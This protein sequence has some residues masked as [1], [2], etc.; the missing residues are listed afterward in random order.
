M[1]VS[2]ILIKNGEVIDPA[3]GARSRMDVAISGDRIV[4]MAPALGVGQAK[5]TYDASGKL[6]V[7]GLIDLHTHLGFEVHR[8]V[9]AAVDV[10]PQAGVTAAVDMGSVGAFTFPWYRQR[11]L[12]TCPVR[13]FSFINISSIG[14]IAIHQPYYVNYYADGV[15]LDREDT[16]RTID[17][18]RD[19]VLGIKVFGTAT[20]AG[21]WVLPALR[22]AREVADLTHVPIA[23]HVSKEPPPLDEILALLRQGDMITH[24]YTPLEQGILDADGKVRAVVRE[25]RERGVLFDLGHGS[26]SFTFE[27]AR[28]AMEQ[29]FLPDTIS[30]DVYYS[31]VDGPVKDLPT[32]MGK[33]LALGLPIEEVLS[34]V[35]TAPAKAMGRPDLG[36]LREGG[37]ADLAVLSLQEGRFGYIDSRKQVVEGPWKIECELTVCRGQLIYRKEHAH[38]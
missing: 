10:C 20:M 36:A 13:L 4:S 25:A 5:Q 18:N 21:E 16:A 37:P 15:Y 2:D 30:T 29:G 24:S 3:S 8:K 28:K 23:V 17:E 26:G 34:R 14:T 7:P 32:T 38:D 9:V 1:P 19:Y 12:E 6:V 27:T 31:N 33:F 22:A 11:V 35:T